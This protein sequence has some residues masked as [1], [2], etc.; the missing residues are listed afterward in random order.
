MPTAFDPAWLAALERRADVPPQRP[1]ETLATAD[2]IAIGSLEPALGRALVDARQPLA[3]ASDGWRLSGETDDALASIAA[4]LH[5]EGHGGRW[6]DELLAVT[7]T[8]GKR[9]GI[10]VGAIERAAVRPLGISTL[11]VH[12]VGYDEAGRIWVQQRAHDKA[13]DPGMWDTLVGGLV[14]AG[15]STLPSLERETRE[16]AGLRLAAL[17]QLDSYGAVLVRRP[18]ADGYMVERIEMFDAL[19]P[20]GAEP[21]NQDGEVAGFE[22]LEFP[23]LRERLQADRFTLEAALILRAWVQRRRRLG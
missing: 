17:E 23:A 19:V 22:L 16:E 12:L 20:T 1:R 18:V 11:A 5:R 4:W 9:A 14:A 13:T 7:A 2:G 8:A 15:E 21:E 3:A 6:R 10:A